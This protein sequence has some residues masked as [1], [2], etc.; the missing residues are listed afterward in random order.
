MI[1]TDPIADL[2]ARLRNGAGARHAVVEM[3]ATKMKL[4]VL[5][6]LKDEGFIKDFDVIKGTH[7]DLARVELKYFQDRTTAILV[8]KCVSRPGRRVYVGAAELPKVRGGLGIAIVS[9]PKGIMTDRSA[10]KLRVGG[11]WLCSVW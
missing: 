1:V 10:R 3:P 5:Q 11:E 2:L 6:I 9:T 8:A 4:A 7:W